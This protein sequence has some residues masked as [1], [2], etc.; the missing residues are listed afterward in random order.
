METESKYENVIKLP[1]AIRKRQKLRPAFCACSAAAAI[2]VDAPEAIR[3]SRIKCMR[4]LCVLWALNFSRSRFQIWIL[5]T[6]AGRVVEWQ[7]Q[8]TPRGESII[9]TKCDNDVPSKWFI[10]PCGVLVCI[11]RRWTFWLYIYQ[12]AD[13]GDGEPHRAL[14]GFCCCAAWNKLKVRERAAR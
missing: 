1:I 4:R 6:L 9:K 3:F 8:S 2:E 5:S 10:M 14:S 12:S 11:K 13:D 7:G